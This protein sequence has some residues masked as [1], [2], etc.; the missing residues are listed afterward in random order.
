MAPITSVC[1]AVVTSM[2]T[3]ASIAQQSVISEAEVLAYASKSYDKAAFFVE[4][5]SSLG[6]LNGID[7]VVEYIC[8]DICPDYTVR[9]IRFAVEPGSA[10]EGVGGVEKVVVVPRGIASG[11]RTFCF[12]RVI[13]EHWDAYIR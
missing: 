12:P 3:A 1:V 11:P 8:S 7:V 9:I 10:C 6:M 4:R 5:R 13:A 2:V